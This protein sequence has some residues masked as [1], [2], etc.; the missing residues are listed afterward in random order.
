MFKLTH[1]VAVLTATA[2]LA[3]PGNT[4]CQIPLPDP[5]ASAPASLQTTIL[6][7]NGYKTTTCTQASYSGQLNITSD[8]SSYSKCYSWPGLGIKVS[9]V[10]SGCSGGECWPWTT[11]QF[12]FFFNTWILSAP[13]CFP[14]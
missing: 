5:V 4:D 10:C 7:L 8:P 14:F 2:A 9:Y 12:Y 11:A 1:F 13:T 6:T 3:L